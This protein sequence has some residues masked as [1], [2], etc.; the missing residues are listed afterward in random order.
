MLHNLKI[1]DNFT[2]KIRLGNPYDGG[3]VVPISALGFSDALFSYGV[4]GDISFERDYALLTG[5]KAYCFDHTIGGV[6]IPPE[7]E[8]KIIF[9][10]EGLSGEDGEDTKHFFTHYASEK[11]DGQKVLLKLDIEGCEYEFFDKTDLVKLASVVSGMVIEFHYFNLPETYEKFLLLLE[12]L[13]KFFYIVHIHG[14]NY[15]GSNE[16]FYNGK[17]YIMP[18]FIEVSFIN[19]EISP[20][21]KTSDGPHPD[22]RL[23]YRNEA[24]KEEHNLDFLK[25]IA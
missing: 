16:Y 3:Y 2:T 9:K 8:G 6:G 10:K 14:N 5:K 24:S 13:N 25:L 19:K 12:K 4:G 20:M 17:S 18:H 23:D 1:Y 15:G 22:P 21:P 11:F 7:V